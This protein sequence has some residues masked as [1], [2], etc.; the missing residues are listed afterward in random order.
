MGS[1][2]DNTV[3][4]IAHNLGY[5]PFFIAFM[6]DLA[7]V[8]FTSSFYCIAP[9]YWY[10]SAVLTPLKDIAGFVYADDTN[11]YLKAYYQTNAIGTAKSFN[12]Y[13]KI[14]KN[15]LGL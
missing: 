14:F 8:F 10:R 12:W 7:G 3:K 9:Y 13:Y 2:S 6:N 15:N 11:L 5:V 1:V 4:T